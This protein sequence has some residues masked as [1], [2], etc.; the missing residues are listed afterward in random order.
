ME[1]GY[2]DSLT[3]ILKGGFFVFFGS[4]FNRISQLITNILLT[5]ALSIEEFGLFNLC[6]SIFFPLRRLSTF[7]M[8]MS[9]PRFFSMARTKEDVKEM[10][11]I[12]WISFTLTLLLSLVFVSAL[13]IFSSQLSDVFSSP[14]LNKLLKI[15]AFSLLFYAFIDIFSSILR[16]NF[17][18]KFGVLVLDIIPRA[19]LLIGFAITFVIFPS[20]LKFSITY[21]ISLAIAFMLGLF[22]FFKKI[23]SFL[24]KPDI[25]VKYLKKFLIFSLPLAFSILLESLRGRVS[26][27]L[28]GILLNPE[29]VGLYAVALNFSLLLLLIV[30]S[31]GPAYIPFLSRHYA[32]GETEV[33]K[34]IFP[35][36]AKWM[37]IF[38]YVL[39]LVMFFFAPYIIWILFGKQYIYSANLFKIMSIS[40][41]FSLLFGQTS[42]IILVFGKPNYL[43]LFN[44]MFTILIIL[45]DLILIPKFELT[46]AA[47]A[48]SIAY[49]FRSLLPAWYIYKK[50]GI[51]SISANLIKFALIATLAPILVLYLGKTLLIKE[52]FLDSL[53]TGI[54]LVVISYFIFKTITK[55]EKKLILG[56]LVPIS[57]KRKYMI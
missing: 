37:L 26:I 1:K 20:L 44:L 25:D 38:T 24:K 30:N 13:Y 36:V 46:G 4:I 50:W 18:I 35:I 57:S 16:G 42:T 5:R 28:V 14:V 56:L 19:A 8:R 15:M 21:V 43:L 3:E 34:V 10:N 39:F 11:Q 54:T 33:I 32:S 29:A 31:L 2:F 55:D 51:H 17:D 27:Y 49:F 47:I 48:F 23:H 41:I 12:I 9:V 6:I 53:V 45:F 22:I 40:I 52:I 7:G